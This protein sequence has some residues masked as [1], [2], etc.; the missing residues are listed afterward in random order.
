MRYGFCKEGVGVF[1]GRRAAAGQGEGRGPDVQGELLTR[2][3]PMKKETAGRFTSIIHSMLKYGCAMIV[4]V[5]IGAAVFWY[6]TIGRRSPSSMEAARAEANAVAKSV[7]ETLRVEDMK[8]ELARTGAIVREKAKHAGAT[9]SDAASNAK[10][11]AIIKGRFVAD[12]ELPSLQI[13]VD[14][15]DGVVTLSGKADSVQIVAKAVRIALDVE[16]VKK[17]YSTIQVVPEKK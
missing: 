17:V 7:G 3:S 9:L 13:G 11:T 12:R 10:I 14:T 4:G 6:L 1:V 15:T 5:L 8:D 16:G 2:F